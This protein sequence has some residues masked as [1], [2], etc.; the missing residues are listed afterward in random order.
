MTCPHISA[1]TFCLRQGLGK[2][3][4]TGAEVSP[5]GIS[6]SNLGAVAVSPLP[7]LL[8]RSPLYGMKSC[9]R[10]GSV[11]LPGSSLQ[12]R[13][14]ISVT[15]LHSA[16]SSGGLWGNAVWGSAASWLLCGRS[17][18]LPLEKRGSRRCLVASSGTVWGGGYCSGKNKSF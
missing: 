3:I 6:F 4:S 15:C 14:N 18:V 7:D 2:H 16:P 10:C 11:E 5:S 8:Y 12:R 9:A 1:S 17:L 13:W